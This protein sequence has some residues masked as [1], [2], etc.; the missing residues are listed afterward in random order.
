MLT[1]RKD[2]CT[3]ALFVTERK[4]TKGIVPYYIF[5]DS[6]DSIILYYTCLLGAGD[7]NNQSYNYILTKSKTTTPLSKGCTF[8]GNSG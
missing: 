8:Y 2:Y 3:L 4:D 1:L 5:I 7:N 6:T